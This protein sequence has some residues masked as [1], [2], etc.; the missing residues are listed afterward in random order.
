QPAVLGSAI[1]ISERLRTERALRDSEEKARA[2]VDA[3]PDFILR[4]RGDGTILDL[5]APKD[6][7][8]SI[9]VSELLGKALL[10][11]APETLAGAT[12]YYLERTLQTAE[13]HSF[14]FQ[15]PLREEMRD[16]EARVAVCGANEVL[17]IVRDVTERKRLEKQVQGICARERRRFGQ[18]LHDGLGQFLA[19]IAMK[20]KI[21]EDSLDRDA[22]P[23][24]GAAKKVVR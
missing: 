20:A 19:G 18:D 7:D 17:C 10:E 6:A 16:F 15:L 21:L 1:D 2:L 12:R 5:K 14:E 3:I 11:L 24:K 8:L 22:S 13:V 9:R 4:L 23:H